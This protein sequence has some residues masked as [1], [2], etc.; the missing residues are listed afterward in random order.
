MAV[1]LVIDP[2]ITYATYFGATGADYIRAMTTDASGNVYI[3]GVTQGADF[4]A[5][6][7]AAPGEEGDGYLAKLR[8]D[9]SL[10]W[11]TMIGGAEGDG[12]AAL[13]MGPEGDVFVAG[14]TWSDDFPITP[15]A[16]GSMGPNVCDT[17][18]ARVRADGTLRAATTL[19]A[20]QPWGQ[21][22]GASAI[23]VDGQGRPHVV[24]ARRQARGSCRRE[25]IAMERARRGSTSRT[26][27]SR[28]SHPISRPSSCHA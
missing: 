18:V 12:I 26:A 1:P 22:C 5:P 21:G 28:A 11:L 7:A 27:S 6:G 17:F 24:E 8:A 14:F 2:T 16:Y 10:A 4:P 13:A 23:A 20:P 3:A 25:V 19:K 9:G 15:G